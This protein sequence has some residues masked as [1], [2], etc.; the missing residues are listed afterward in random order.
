MATQITV[1]RHV[2]KKGWKQ[3]Y[4]AKMRGFMGTFSK[5][6][7]VGID[8]I[9]SKQ[10]MFMR[11]KLRGKA[12][13]LM[14]KNTLM[15]KCLRDMS[16]EAGEDGDASLD[17][18]VEVIKGNIGL[19]FTDMDAAECRELLQEDKVQAP[20]K[21]GQSAPCDV[22]INAGPTGMDAQKTSFFQALNLPTKIIKGDIN[23]LTKQ[24]VCAVGENVGVSEAKLLNMLDISPF[25]Y[26]FL[27]ENC[28]EG[29]SVFPP[30]VLDITTDT[31]LGHF[32]TGL[33]NIASIGLALG[34]PNK[35]SVVHSILNGFNLVFSLALG[36]DDI[37]LSTPGF[38]NANLF[39]T[40]P[41]AWAAANAGGGGSGGGT[42][43]DTGDGVPVAAVATEPE[44]ESESDEDMEMG[45]FD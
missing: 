37:T 13:M 38:A 16:E 15:R 11:H 33:G 45:L 42:S 5:I 1:D 40:D 36:S 9:G 4:F 27:L 12:E 30:S 39:K 6:L 23:I 24:K 14:G 17:A 8:N 10:M 19:V 3:A 31:L 25:F 32:G 35:A 28:F 41:E 2:D 29:G 21:S 18:L 7:I 44:P 20:A 34:L 26:G 43:A 22:W